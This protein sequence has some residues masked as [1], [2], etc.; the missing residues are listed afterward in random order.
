M[1]VI[2]YLDDQWI[3]ITSELVT[4]KTSG[5][6]LRTDAIGG[7]RT[8]RKSQWH[9]ISLFGWL[10]L[11]VGLNYFS[12]GAMCIGAMTDTINEVRM[13]GAAIV[14][15]GIVVL[16][17]SRRLPPFN[18]YVVVSAGGAERELVYSADQ[19]WSAKV[20]ESIRAAMTRLP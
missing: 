12:C 8:Y 4:I 10:L 6:T 3:S 14:V 16:Y 17:A 1:S 20:A 15:G 2:T 13:T 7:V 11:L 9:W 5:V 18:H 19:L